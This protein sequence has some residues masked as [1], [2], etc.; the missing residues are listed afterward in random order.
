MLVTDS[1]R[2]RGRALSDVVRAAVGGGANIVQVREKALSHDE[3]VVLAA[4]LRRLVDGR[5]LLLVNGDVEAAVEAG[6]DGVHLPADG[7]RV[8]EARTRLGDAA[9]ISRAVHSIAEAAT[10]GRDG[11]DL[12]V[13]GTVFP[14]ASH[15]GGITIGVDGVRAACASARVPVIAIGG[16]TAGNAGEV[17]RAGASGVAAIGAIFDAEDAREAARALRAAIDTARRD[18]SPCGSR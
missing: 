6:A 10:A 11:A 5:A 18:G 17:M 12:I 3:L 1:G 15:P 9:L 4:H 16:V 7:R 8:A 2:L 14:S 13:L